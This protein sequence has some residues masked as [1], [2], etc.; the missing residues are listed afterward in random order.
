M[1]FPGELDRLGSPISHLEMDAASD[2]TRNSTAAAAQH[3]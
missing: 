2:S 3:A 1:E